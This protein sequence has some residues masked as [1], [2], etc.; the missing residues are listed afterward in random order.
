[1]KTT[2]QYKFYPD[3]NQKLE[4]NE[5]LRISRYWY[6]RQLGDRFDWW[7]MNRTRVDACPLVSSIAPV[8]EKPNYYTQKQQLPILKKD[9]VKVLHSGE[10]LDFSRVDSTVLQDISKRVD[11]AF[12]RFIVGDSKGGKSGKPRFKSSSSFRTMT[13]AT[14]QDS[15]IKL[16]RENWLY[17]RLPKL[18]IIKVRMH[19][20]IPDGF[21]LKQVSVT[22]KADGW[23]IQLILEDVNVKEENHDL[24]IPTW[25]N[26]LGMDAVLHEDVYLATSEGE[27]LPSLKP[28]AKNQ[29]KLDRISTKRNKRKHGSK[30]RRKLAKRE[31]KQ[32]LRI[33]RS[34]QDFQDKTAHRLVRTG[35]KVFFHEALNLKGLTK[36]NK[37]KQDKDGTYL[38]NGQS[39][40]SGLN[41]SWSDAGFGNFFKTL[42]YI[43]SKAGA[44]VISLNPA[45]TSMVL[46]YRDEIIFTDCSSRNYWDEQNSLMVERDINAAINLKRLGLGIFPSIKRRSGKLS[47]VGTIDDST[48]KEILH[49][50]HR[51][52]RSPHHT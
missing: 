21:V 1:M 13:F 43:A 50:L 6:N 51:A 46:S 32:H 40:K 3:T 30:A 11:K 47:I 29:A 9:L 34:R 38:P 20:P 41:K 26:S 23:F 4:L 16:T 12:K 15:W 31:A 33:A 39:A 36:R 22:K 7:Q 37:T 48:T 52:A 10:L 42:D 35:K 5:W 17:L 25:E 27:K 14:A 24:I 45:Y 19:R 18:G 28:I 2:Y 49:T 44:V 8:R